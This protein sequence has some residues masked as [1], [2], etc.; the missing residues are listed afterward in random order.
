MGGVLVTLL[1]QV[2]K[3]SAMLGRTRRPPMDEKD[4]MDL[5][6]ALLMRKG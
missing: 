4:M 6:K 5:A 3:K 1:T 2:L